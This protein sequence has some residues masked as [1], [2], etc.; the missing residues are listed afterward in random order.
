MTLLE[1]TWPL[2]AMALAA[3]AAG[4]LLPLSSEAA[5]AAAI[6]SGV[7]KPWPLVASATV[8]NVLG[9][10]FNWWVGLHMRRFEGRRWFPFKSE[11]VDAASSRFQRY[12]TWCLL[13]SWLP[14]VGDP[15]TVAAGLLRVPFVPFLVL[16]T[17][18]KAAR[19]VALAAIM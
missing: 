19:Y 4:T 10:C 2:L 17:C 8:G 9:A 6:V 7:A 18:G 15:L 16:V 11:T 1:L 5:L 3:F 13:F 12:G 14:I